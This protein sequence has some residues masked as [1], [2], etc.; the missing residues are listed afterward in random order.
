MSEMFLP[1]QL[2][3]VRMGF[4]LPFHLHRTKLT[5]ER[6]RS[7]DLTLTDSSTIIGIY[8]GLFH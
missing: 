3:M 4:E 7:L 2:Y 8:V 6:P 1:G 5:V